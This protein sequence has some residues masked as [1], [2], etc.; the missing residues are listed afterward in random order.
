MYNFKVND[1][2]IMTKSCK[3]AVSNTVPNI[4]KVCTNHSKISRTG[5]EKARVNTEVEHM[6]FKD[7]SIH[8]QS[9]L[10]NGSTDMSEKL[11]LQWND[12]QENIKSAFGIGCFTKT[13]F[14][15]KK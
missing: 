11:C 6:T 8:I 1:I 15:I 3:Y 2:Q 5:A 4:R 14:Q 10:R 13:L 12:F 7:I 9:T